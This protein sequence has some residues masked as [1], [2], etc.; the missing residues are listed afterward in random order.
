[1]SG[2]QKNTLITSII[3]AYSVLWFNLPEIAMTLTLALSA[4][5]CSCF[6]V[7]GISSSDYELGQRVE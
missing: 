2:L 6:Y 4:I 3:I 7:S 1:M 5:Y